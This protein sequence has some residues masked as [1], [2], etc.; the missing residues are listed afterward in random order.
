MSPPHTDAY[1][2]QRVIKSSLLA[3][4]SG[5]VLSIPCLDYDYFYFAWVGFVPLLYAL[6]NQSLRSSYF[7]GLLAGLTTMA[8]ATYWMS[9]FI[10][11]SKNYSGYRAILLA[12]VFWLYQA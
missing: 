12:M 8:S 5:L 1:T 11:L 9:D 6:E 7:Y 3:I 4:I 10:V 2:T